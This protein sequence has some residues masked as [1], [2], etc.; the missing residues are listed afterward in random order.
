M[1]AAVAGTVVA[2]K[3]PHPG[4]VES[5]RRDFALMLRMAQL[6]SLLPGLHGLHLEET[7]AQF[8]APLQEQ[9][10]SAWHHPSKAPPLIPLPLTP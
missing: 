10:S 6:T 5:I 1:C 3:V 8:A 2:V 7:L 9:V 4:V